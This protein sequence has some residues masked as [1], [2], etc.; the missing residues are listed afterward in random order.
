MPCTTSVVT[1]LS[2]KYQ[3]LSGSAVPLVAWK[4]S[5]N[6]A[7]KDNLEFKQQQFGESNYTNINADKWSGSNSCGHLLPTW[8]SSD[9][10]IRVTTLPRSP[11]STNSGLPHYL[12]H[13]ISSPSVGHCWI[14]FWSHN[15]DKEHSWILPLE[16]GSKPNI[17]IHHLHNAMKMVEQ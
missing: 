8:S 7:S 12:P 1:R 17:Y 3:R 16:L 2:A 4:S 9:G 14:A 10:S 6:K 13:Q 15:W 5:V 11:G